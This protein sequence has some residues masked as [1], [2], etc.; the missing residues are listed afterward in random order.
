MKR[1]IPILL[2]TT[3]VLLSCQNKKTEVELNKYISKEKIEQQNMKIVSKWIEEVNVNNF[4]ELYEELFTKEFKHY[5]P[6][7]AQPRSYQEY[8]ENGKQIYSAFHN[9]SHTIEELIAKDNKVIARMT[10]RAIHGGDFYGLPASGNKLEWS[11]IA[12]FELSDGKIVARW[13]EVNLLELYKQMGMELKS[14]KK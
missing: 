4:E 8:K 11:A 9:L 14:E 1:Q 7:N 12:I 10:A 2:L 6:S 3:F 5:V 13:E